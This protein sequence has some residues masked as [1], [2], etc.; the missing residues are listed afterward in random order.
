MFSF[1]IKY[2]GWKRMRLTDVC[3]V[4]QHGGV[5]GDADEQLELVIR[6]P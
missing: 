3:Q 1:G 2:V 5:R 4:L 6:G